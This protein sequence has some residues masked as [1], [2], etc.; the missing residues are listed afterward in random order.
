[1]PHRTAR[2]EALVLTKDGRWAFFVFCR[3]RK[4]ARGNAQTL[5]GSDVPLSQRAFSPFENGPSAPASIRP[6]PIRFDHDL[7]DRRSVRRRYGQILRS[8][9]PRR[10]HL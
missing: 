3:R 7:R 10:L 5:V 9:V 2:R 8:R 6:R 4:S 1:M